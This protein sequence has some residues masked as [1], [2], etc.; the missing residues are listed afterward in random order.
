MQESF[1]WWQ[2]SHRYIFPSSPHLRQSLIGLVVSVDV[3][4]RERR[5]RRGTPCNDGT[6][7]QN[8][9]VA[10]IWL[11]GRAKPISAPQHA[12]HRSFRSP[13]LSGVQNYFFSLNREARSVGIRVREKADPVNISNTQDRGL[14]TFNFKHAHVKNRGLVSS[15]HKHACVRNRGFVISN[16]KH[17]CLRNRG[18]VT[19]NYKY[20]RVRNRGLVTANY[21]YAR[22]RNRGLVTANYKYAWQ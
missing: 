19:S 10:N 20:A 6:S 11:T 1:W 7:R 3:K 12:T 18:P 14:V 2:C 17:A 4:H 22:V 5:R 15:N 16:Y 8:Y 21:K 9:R 13:V